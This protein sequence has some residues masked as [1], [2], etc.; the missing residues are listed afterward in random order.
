MSR[1]VYILLPVL[2]EAANIGPLLDAVELALRGQD[3]MIGI[4]DDGS[5]DGTLEIL[6]ER[7]R[8]PGQRLHLIRRI[9]T[10]RASQRGSALRILMEWGL[11]N[12]A[13]GIFVEMDGDRSHRPEE[14]AE[15]IRLAGEGGFD[16]AIASKYVAGSL[17]T[18]R[19]FGRRM[20]SKVCSYTV[21]LMI[22]SRVRDYSNGYRFYTREA[23]RVAA[24]HAYR[25]G[26]PIYLSEI[27]ALWLREGMRVGEFP[28]TYIGRNEG[29]S[30]LRISDLAK[31]GIAI[32]EIAL[33]YHLFGFKRAAQRLTPAHVAAVADPPRART[34]GADGAGE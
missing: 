13:H 25:Y 34:A 1:G 12:T 27:L 33:R 22:S 31:A 24:D 20:V 17:V 5:R 18:N 21:R 26:S 10:R 9:K 7:M 23:A 11:K 4:V 29:I 16:V 28:S 3:Y 2:N 8:R 15:G 19:P 6:E 32:F 14:L 30:K